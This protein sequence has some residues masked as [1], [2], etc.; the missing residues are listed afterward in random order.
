MEIVVVSQGI[1][2]GFMVHVVLK[3]KACSIVTGGCSCLKI[4]EEGDVLF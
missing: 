1:K 2:E 3:E 4:A